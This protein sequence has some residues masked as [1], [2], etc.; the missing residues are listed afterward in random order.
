VTAVVQKTGGSSATLSVKLVRAALRATNMLPNIDEDEW[1]TIAEE[2][3]DSINNDERLTDALAGP[4]RS[5]SSEDQSNGM[6][7]AQAT[8]QDEGSD[9]PGQEPEEA[10]E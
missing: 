6:Q 2:L 1:D 9:Q 7:P 8:A 3:S 5:D 4:T 10:D